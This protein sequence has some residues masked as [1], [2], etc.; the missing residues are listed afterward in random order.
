MG[1]QQQDATLFNPNKLNLT[2]IATYK[3]CI[4]ANLDRVWENILDWE[5]LPWLHRSSFDYI[6]LIDAGDWGWRTWSNTDNTAY[7]ELCVDKDNLQYVARSYQHGNQLSEIWTRLLPVDA[8]TNIDVSFQ[9]VDLAESGKNRLANIYLSLYENLWDEDELMMMERH[10]RLSEKQQAPDQIN[11]GPKVDLISRLPLTV[12]L[13]HGTWQVR[14]YENEIVVHSA[15]C[16]H[17]LGPLHAG[18]LNDNCI[19]CPWHGYEFDIISGSCVYPLDAKCQLPSP[20]EIQE[21][22]KKEIVL[23]FNHA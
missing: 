15:I 20:P 9:V 14:E 12:K 5:H 13:G 11:L 6:S 3:R 4:H 17:R 19:I 8:N 1:P 22:S 16:A 23:I 7:I 21:N 2:E 10:R 18:E